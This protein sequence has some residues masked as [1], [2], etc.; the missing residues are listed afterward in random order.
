MK[1]NLGESPQKVKPSSSIIFPIQGSIQAQVGVT[2]GQ[3]EDPS[4]HGP[5]M[6]VK[7]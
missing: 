1:G 2:R 3:Y 5:A 7:G 6:Y 4:R